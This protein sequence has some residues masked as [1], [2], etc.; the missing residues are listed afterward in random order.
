M[1]RGGP[2]VLKLGDG[3]LFYS[4]LGADQATGLL[5]RFGTGAAILCRRWAWVHVPIHKW[6]QRATAAHCGIRPADEQHS[7]PPHFAKICFLKVYLLVHQI[8]Y[9]RAIISKLKVSCCFLTHRGGTN[10]RI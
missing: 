8:F 2:S 5:A 7:A 1:R 10:I 6:L 9:A 3:G 4:L